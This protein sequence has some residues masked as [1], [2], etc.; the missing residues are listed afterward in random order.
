MIIL[1][2][3]DYCFYTVFVRE[4]V[5]RAFASVTEVCVYVIYCVCRHGNSKF[6]HAQ[7][8]LNEHTSLY[9]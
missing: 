7:N 3:Y 8:P 2:S 1:L 5:L 6:G 4:L 9:A